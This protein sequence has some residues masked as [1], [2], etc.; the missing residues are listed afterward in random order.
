MNKSTIRILV[1]DDES[2][3]LKLLAHMLAGL[4][5]TSVTTCDKGSEALQYVSVGDSPP[6]LI[7][8]D[9]QMPGMDGIEFVRKLVEHNYT[10]NLI[11]VSGE[12]ERVLQMAE[13]LIQAHRITVLGHLNKPVSLDLLSMLM[14][15]S[16]HMHAALQSTTHAYSADELRTAIDAGELVNYY[17]PKV[18]VTTGAVVGVETL[19]R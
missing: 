2:F 19:V 12:N 5:F 15:K 9:L 1:L 13:K 11:L 6:N 7:L 10:G 14:E 3:M 16:V 8:L 18:A 4:G 17:Q